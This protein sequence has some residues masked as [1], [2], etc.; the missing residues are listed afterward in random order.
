MNVC[1]SCKSQ[2]VVTGDAIDGTWFRPQGL[3]PLSFRPLPDAVAA[4]CHVCL[5][6][7]LLWH[8]V[9]VDELKQYV[10]KYGTEET[11]TEYGCTGM[12]AEQEKECRERGRPEQV[13][14]KSVK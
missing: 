6:C 9:S 5:D 2:R 1:I 3:R 14:N 13:L 8:R 12:G 11:K 4:S 7:G 10:Q